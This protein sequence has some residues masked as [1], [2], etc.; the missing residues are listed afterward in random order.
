MPTQWYISRDQ[1]KVGPF[2]LD[3]I[4]QLASLGILRKTEFILTEGSQRWVAANSIYGLFPEDERQRFWLSFNGQVL[5]PFDR[6]T[7]RNAVLGGRVPRDAHVC[8]EGTKQWVQLEQQAKFH[9]AVKAS[10]DS[11]VVCTAALSE[12]EAELHLAGKQGDSIA[13][14]V[15]TLMDLKRRNATNNSLVDIID[16]NIRD[17]LSLRRTGTMPL[18]EASRPTSLPA[19]KDTKANQI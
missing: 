13:R 4:K 19:A 15:S 7:I 6:A 17:L 16:K 11:G 10:R 2:S 3:E 5:G 9:D 8:P 14:L 12:Q 1:Q 18:D